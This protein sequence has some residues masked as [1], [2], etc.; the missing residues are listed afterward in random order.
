MRMKIKIRSFCNLRMTPTSLNK[1]PD[2]YL[3]YY[4]Q[5]TKSNAS[6][7]VSC[8]CGVTLERYHPNLFTVPPASAC[9][10]YGLGNILVCAVFHSNWMTCSQLSRH[11]KQQ[12]VVE[13]LTKF[14]DIL[15]EICQR[16]LAFYGEDT[17]DISTV[18]C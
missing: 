5:C 17:V 15:T 2:F 6:M 8:A 7:H 14:N 11:I 16:F 3:L 18:C 10:C 12:A 13:F 1:G 9:M 4:K